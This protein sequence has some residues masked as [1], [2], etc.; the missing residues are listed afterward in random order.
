MNSLSSLRL[1]S[2][3][4]L[5]SDLK[6]ESLKLWEEKQPL[7]C[8]PLISLAWAHLGY[9][10]KAEEWLQMAINSDTEL[11]P[12]GL[13]DLAGV[14]MVS[15]RFENAERY[16]KKALGQRGD[17]S[18]A[19][20]RLGFCYMMRNDLTSAVLLYERSLR[21]NPRRITVH[22]NLVSLYIHQEQYDLAE[23]AIENSYIKYYEYIDDHTEELNKQYLFKLDE[24]RLQLWVVTAQFA[25]AEHWL[26]SI[27]ED[28]ERF[29]IL[30]QR[31]AA[32]L[33]EADYHA[34][35][36]EFIGTLL[37]I[38]PNDT[39]LLL[40]KSELS[41]I[42]G[43]TIQA[44]NLLRKA[45]SQDK[46]NPRLWVELSNACLHR[47]GQQARE[48]AEKAVELAAQLEEDE[49]TP[50]EKIA[51]LKLQAKN[52]LA[53]VECQEENFERSE[54]LFN[55]VLAEQPWFLP[56]LQGL[57]QQSMQQGNI[58]RAI[59]LFEKVKQLDPV[60]GYT[61]LINARQFPDDEDTLHKMEQAALR[62][63]L[64]GKMRSG[65]LFQLASAWE[66]R[67]DYDKAF[68]LVQKAN[69]A[70]RKFLPYKAKQHRNE[71]ARIRMAFCKALYE[72]RPNYGSDSTVPV[73]VLGMPRSGTT[74][75]EQILSGHSQIFGAG[76]LGV[77]PQVAQGLER[78][79]R[80]VGSG[81][82]YPDCIDD[83]TK[84][85]TQAI[86]DNV[87]KELQ[88]YAPE[89]KHIVDKLPHNFENIGLIKFLFPNARIISVRRDPRDIAISNYFTDYQAK[90]G[91]MGFAYD[92]TDIG[93]QLAD[94]NLLMHHWQQVFPGEI[95]E[96]NYEDVVEDLEGSAR[97]LLD[98]IGVEW[99]PQVLKFNELERT[100]KT[101]SVWQVRQPIYKTSKAKWKR[102][103]D[104][105]APL[106]QGTNAKIEWDPIEDM[107]T[108]PEAG[109]LTK[110]VE[111]YKQ[112]NLDEAELSFKK[113]L[114]HNPDH[115]AC[116]YMT[117]L[118]YFCKNHFKDGITFVETAL[119]KAPCH[120]EWQQNLIKAY[121][122]IGDQD[123]AALLRQKYRLQT[124]E[125]Q[126]EAQLAD[127][128]GFDLENDLIRFRGIADAS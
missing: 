115:A 121:E 84:E 102:Y 75:V 101:A 92:L 44:V 37:Q 125:E 116:N 113:M 9:R 49:E 38:L 33:A 71:C 12:A 43:H 63:G 90:H 108:L 80:H 40:Q 110:G 95:L 76:E 100:V 127:A 46:E 126:A 30:C 2:E 117:G 112:G 70:S 35:A 41:Q 114:H 83:L 104:Y 34:Q 69:D 32:M 24:A 107:I 86:A 79:E 26:S 45:I 65:I 57:G 96:I 52:A 54:Q 66:K 67:K 106:I 62:P 68:E 82:H 85:V 72:H 48:A 118:V 109:F 20:A 77:I 31:Y 28:L 13:T 105:L 51:L 88:E 4:H 39:D 47:M 5:W 119:K 27:D 81:R 124:P 60:R 55:E 61:S 58:D 50:P 17:L 15:M 122:I 23:I 29:K 64:E 6:A 42:Q 11:T 14:L 123:Q 25:E 16:L 3:Q 97:K 87:L 111:H 59:E 73:Y 128:A 89:A 91:G 36:A 99:E 94:H 120:K 93:E 56:A 8:L 19:H 74:L 103:E 53:Q 7:D 21:I 98:Y 18:L 1:L 22:S 10:A 78:W